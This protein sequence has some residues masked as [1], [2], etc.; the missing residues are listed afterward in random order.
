MR[1][2]SNLEALSKVCWNCCTVKPFHASTDGNYDE[3]E[4][5]YLKQFKWLLLDLS[6][7]HFVRG[8]LSYSPVLRFEL[9]CGIQG[10]K[11][12]CL[13]KASYRSKV[14]PFF[15]TG[16]CFMNDWVDYFAVGRNWNAALLI[17]CYPECQYC[18]EICKTLQWWVGYSNCFYNNQYNWLKFLFILFSWH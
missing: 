10:E 17:I 4:N 5:V 18:S 14:A 9:K 16:Q 1:S 2:H 7:S 13:V 8:L 15:Y 3:T 6:V 12:L 11:Y